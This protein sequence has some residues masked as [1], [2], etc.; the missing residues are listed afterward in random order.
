MKLGFLAACLP[1]SHHT[2][3]PCLPADQG[4]PGH[5]VTYG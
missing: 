2:G 3:K 1:E 4:F 5:W